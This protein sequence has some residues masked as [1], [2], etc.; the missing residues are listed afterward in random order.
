MILLELLLVL[1]S[2]IIVYLLHRM[3]RTAKYGE[4]RQYILKTEGYHDFH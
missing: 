3:P 2:L 4:T 1:L